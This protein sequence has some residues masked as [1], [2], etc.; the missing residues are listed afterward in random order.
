LF[1][2]SVPADLARMLR[3]DTTFAEN[4]SKKARNTTFVFFLIKG[5]RDD[6]ENPSSRLAALM[7]IAIMFA[8]F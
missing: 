5:S 3:R 8:A 1:D 2:I 7:T 4:G 6:L